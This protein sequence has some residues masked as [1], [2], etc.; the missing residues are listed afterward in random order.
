MWGLEIFE[1]FS[2]PP[3]VLHY[4]RR[5]KEALNCLYRIAVPNVTVNL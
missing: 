3:A 1:L 5:Y 4:D 2:L